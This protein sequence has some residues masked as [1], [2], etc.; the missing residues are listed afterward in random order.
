MKLAEI[1]KDRTLLELGRIAFADYG[2]F[3][4]EKGNIKKISELS[5]DQRALLAGVETIIKNAEAG[6]G[7]TDRVH[8]IRTWDIYL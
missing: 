2:Q 8:K 4:D 1:T 5:E 6:D 7:H 3:Y